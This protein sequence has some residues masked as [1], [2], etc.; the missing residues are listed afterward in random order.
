VSRLAAVAFVAVA[1]TLAACGG[2]DGGGSST[3]S[4]APA[5]TTAAKKAKKKAV[6]APKPLTGSYRGPVPILMYHVITAPKPGTAYPELWVPWK[7]FAATMYALKEAGYGAVTMAQVWKAWHGGPGLPAKPVVLSF[8]DGYLS[9]STH[10]RPTLRALG[11]PGVLY[12][13]GKNIDPQ[14]GLSRKQVR[15]LIANG[16][17]I[18]AH[19]LTHPE[20]PTV[21]AA[22][23]HDEVTG[24]KEKIERLFHIPVTTFA[25][26]AGKYDDAAVAA[27]K[28]AGYDTAVTVEPGIAAKDQNPLLLPRVRVNGDDTPEAVL[29]RI[30]DLTG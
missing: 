13:E 17:E 11:W 30:R 20:L 12:L 9:H 8:D 24:S 7:T 2:G 19:T 21:G 1:L 6:T 10:A 3:A 28:E 26:P 16:W 14:V 27:V 5:K 25:Y 22:Q 4:P 15:G 18:G 29:Q 23:L